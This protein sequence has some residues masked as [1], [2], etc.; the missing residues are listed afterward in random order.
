MRP[1]LLI[2]PDWGKLDTIWRSQ[3]PFPLWP[4]CEK[5]LLSY[6]LDEAVR[7]GVPSLSIEAVDRPDLIRNWLDKRDLWSRSIEVHSEPGDREDRDLSLI[8]I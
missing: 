4:V 1:W 8:H 3:Q 5:T 2:A 7:Q 6:W